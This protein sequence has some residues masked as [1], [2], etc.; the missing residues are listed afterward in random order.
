MNPTEHSL[1]STMRLCFNIEHTIYVLNI[2]QY[3]LKHN[4]ILCPP[5]QPNS[6]VEQPAA[7]RR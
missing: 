4:K 7:P 1:F 3:M 2:A 5:N 6:N